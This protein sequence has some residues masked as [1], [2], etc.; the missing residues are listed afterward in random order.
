[1]ENM[2][3]TLFQPAFDIFLILFIGVTSIVLRQTIQPVYRG[4]FCDDQSLMH[5]Y[6]SSTIN[7]A[8]LY[9]VSFIIP[10]VTIALVEYVILLFRRKQQGE[11]RNVT[12]DIKTLWLEWLK[13]C[14]RLLILFFYGVAIVHFTTNI[15]KYSLGRLR[16]HFITVCKPDYSKFNCSAG[17]IEDPHC[18][19]DNAK[20]LLEA[21]ISFPSGHASMAVYTMMFTVLYLEKRFTWDG[22]L[23]LKPFIQTWLFYM[24]YY[25]CMTRISDYKHHW[26]DVFGG[27][28]LGFIIALLM[29]YK[30][31]NLLHKKEA[32]LEEKVDKISEGAETAVQV[33]ANCT[34]VL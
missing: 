1:M 22:V 17:F 27:A 13:R 33:H 29:I 15:S 8:L 25:T 6:K 18:T 26:S 12:Q 30:V 4:F 24:A 5:P 3:F 10:F 34:T 2:V 9:S 32:C 20:Q 16:P 23:L 28:I 31:Y 19:G 14:L 21:R 7:A 11:N